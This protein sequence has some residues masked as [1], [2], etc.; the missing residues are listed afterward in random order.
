MS[1]RILTEIDDIESALLRVIST[2]KKDLVLVSPYVQ[3]EASK[4]NRWTELVNLLRAAV[5]RGV[6]ISFISRGQDAY[7][8]DDIMKVLAQFREIGCSVFLLPN[9]H[10]KIYYNESMALVSSMNLYLA[11]TI[12]N[13]EI[14][15]IVDDPGELD[16]IRR[17]LTVLVSK[18][19]S[20]SVGGKRVVKVE[21]APAG[22]KDTFFKV[23]KKGREYY[24]AR[25]EGKYPTRVALSAVP[26]P[27]EPGMSYTCKASVQWRT[28]RSGRK[29]SYL[30]SISNVEKKK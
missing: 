2:A 27:L 20:K 24:H 8:H 28:T 13:H 10:A 29:K 3:I 12:R 11:S 25:L 26:V 22:M 18:N 19:E 23:T 9:L 30:A 1:T 7:H 6:S 17:Y 16:E 15:V 14:G 5:S 4:S 21:K